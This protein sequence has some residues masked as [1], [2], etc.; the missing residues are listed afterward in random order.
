MHGI[1]FLLPR[2][3]LVPLPV[4]VDQMHDA[5]DLVD[6][7]I[8]IRLYFLLRASLPQ[9]EKP[10]LDLG[11]LDLQ[12]RQVSPTGNDALDEVS[13]VGLD[14]GKLLGSRRCRLVDPQLVLDVVLTEL[15]KR[16]RLSLEGL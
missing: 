1:A 13:L 12:W 6:R 7:R 11:R 3:K 14:G 5:P 2:Q 10:S 8:G 4:L 15:A 16:S 9:F